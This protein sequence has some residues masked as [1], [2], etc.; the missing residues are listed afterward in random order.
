MKNGT[1]YKSLATHMRN[2]IP[3]TFL[4]RSLTSLLFL[5]GTIAGLTPAYADYRDGP[6][7]KLAAAKAYVEQ[8]LAEDARPD[9]VFFARDVRFP[10]WKDQ[11][12]HDCAMRSIVRAIQPQEPYFEDEKKRVVIIPVWVELLM[13]EVSNDGGHEATGKEDSSPCTFEYERYSFET[14]RFE[15]IPT[16]RKRTHSEEFQQWGK[17]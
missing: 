13:V 2:Y 7:Q 10:V 16:F 14:H 3:I 5:Y 17:I 11:P 1:R 12:I 6:A 15:K 9:Q 4:L 8:F